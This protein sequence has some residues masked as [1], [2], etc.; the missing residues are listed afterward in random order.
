MENWD[1]IFKKLGSRPPVYD[2]WLDKFLHIIEASK[3]MPVIDLGCGCGN[4]TLY[5]AEKGFDVI[6]CDISAEAL[7]RLDSFIKNP[8][9]KQF[10]MLCGLPFEDN[11]AGIIVS[12]LSLHYFSEADTK[13]IVGE[14]SR[15]LTDGGYFLCRINSTNDINYGAG[16]G[17]KLEDD[18]YCYEG[19]QKRFFTEKSIELFF[20]KWKI[21]YINECEMLRYKLKKI[22]WEFSAGNIKNENN[23]TLR[24]SSRT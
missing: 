3:G 18:F 20:D 11:S 24:K 2:N 16:Q 14:L 10:D 4:D 9:K 13:K 5:L 15:V 21:D 17:E 19:N 22:V 12:D 7:N 23:S 8:R 6:S 1:Q